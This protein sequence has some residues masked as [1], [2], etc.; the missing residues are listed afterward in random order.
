MAPAL[1][2]LALALALA[3]EPSESPVLAAFDFDGDEVETGPYTVIAY[4]HARGTVNLTTRFR[5][6]GTR[7]VEITD[8]AGDGE[9]AELQ[10]FFR[11]M[12]SG[13]VYVHFAFML[14]EPGEAMNIA[15][16][17]AGHFALRQDGFGF[18]LKNRGGV[19]HHVTGGKDV[20]LFRPDAFT[21]YVADVA[22]DIDEGRYD[23]QIVAEGQADPVVSLRSVPNP[24]G[25]RGSHI[26]K[27]SFIGDPPGEDGSNA[28]FYIDDIVVRGDHPVPSEGPLIA[29][30]RRMLFV[31][32]YRYYRSLLYEKPGCLP[33]L[34]P[35]DFGLSGLDM[36]ALGEAGRLRL[37]DQLADRKGAVVPKERD[38]E[39]GERL[40]AMAAWGRGCEAHCRGACALPHFLEA[41]GLA[42]GA[43]MYPMSRVLALAA[44]KRWEEADALF[45]AS[46]PDWRGDPR[47]PALS[48]LLGVARGD[49]DEAERSLATAS[50][51]DPSPAGHPVLRRLWAGELDQALVRDLQAA[52]PD[53]WGDHLESALSAEHRYYVLLWQESYEPAR[54]LADR[55]VARLRGMG[56]APGAWLE[57]RGDALFW[58]GDAR[59]AKESYEEALGAGAERAPV[60]AKLSDV[61]FV[62][63]DLDGERRYREKV[64]GSLRH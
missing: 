41:E 45:A 19:L 14:A 36:Q 39:L 1:A 38:G 51:T 50:D 28:R 59:A 21:W 29:P 57:R 18:W 64:Y 61:H 15:T 23:L 44:E 24:M 12:P 37:Y 27:F 40:L 8:V 7:S 56:L 42:P 26:H 35:E 33:A 16:A 47:F 11:E 30:G 6:S 49:L 62:L 43:K 17:G 25:L 54:A 55:M 13:R 2:G 3:A 46:Y 32:V 31:D 5:H 20:P 22:Y 48:A 52:F 60:Y 34:G 58:L 9:F 4:E 10:G 53:A 63:G